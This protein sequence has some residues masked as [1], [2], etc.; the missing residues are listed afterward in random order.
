MP[1]YDASSANNSPPT[2]ICSRS[3]PAFR[4]SS[5]R[6]CGA[7]HGLRRPRFQSLWRRYGTSQTGQSL[8]PFPI[9]WPLSNGSQERAWSFIERERAI[10]RIS[11]KSQDRKVGR[12]MTRSQWLVAGLCALSYTGSA[13]FGSCNSRVTGFG[14]SWVR[15]NFRLTIWRGGTAWGVVLAP[16][17]PRSIGEVSRSG[18]SACKGGG[19]GVSSNVSDWS[20]QDNDPDHSVV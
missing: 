9:R 5:A 15:G 1:P 18:S 12:A 2:L 6:R 20:R 19:C 14:L 10:E 16:A 17:V 8:R 4:Q 3:P 7:G 11:D 13:K